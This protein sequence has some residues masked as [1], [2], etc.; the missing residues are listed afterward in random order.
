MGENVDATTHAAHWR[1]AMAEPS[2]DKPQ[3]MG[4]VVHTAQLS[5]ANV[6][7]ATDL[8]EPSTHGAHVR[9]LLVVAPAVV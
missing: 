8:N 5:V 3:P 9:S 4:H 6:L 1:S 2:I 7:L